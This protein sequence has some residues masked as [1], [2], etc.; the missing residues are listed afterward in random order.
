MPISSSEE[1]NSAAALV[2]ESQQSVK[3]VRDYGALFRPT[4]LFFLEGGLQQAI[5][6]VKR[7]PLHF[8]EY[9]AYILPQDSNG[10]ELYAS[11]KQYDRHQ[12]RV[13][14]YRVTEKHGFPDDVYAVEHGGKRYGKPRIACNLQ[15]SYRKR[16][17]T[18][19]CQ[20]PQAGVIPLGI[21]RSS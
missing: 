1:L 6:E 18:F 5:H 7:P 16:S 20:I 14:F 21:T 9:P 4:N 17:D 8:V 15:W 2:L 11:Q 3:S 12:G 19:H 10:H 13:A